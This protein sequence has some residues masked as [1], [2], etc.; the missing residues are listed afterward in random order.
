MG[1]LGGNVEL[2]DMVQQLFIRQDG[3]RWFPFPRSVP[4]AAGAT[5]G[6]G[7]FA[8]QEARAGDD[9]AAARI[10]EDG[11]RPP[12]QGKASQPGMCRSMNRP[13]H[14]GTGQITPRQAQE[15]TGR[16]LGCSFP[17]NGME[18]LRFSVKLGQF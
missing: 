10:M 16:T 4:E 6:K 18:D 7:H 8:E 9:Q 15:N 2:A 11:R 14:T 5:P 12:L 17:L 13:Y 1:K 3:A